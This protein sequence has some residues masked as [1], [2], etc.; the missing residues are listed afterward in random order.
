MG[1][2]ERGGE[3]CVGVGGG[4]GGGRGWCPPIQV[5]VFHEKDQLDGN[6]LTLFIWRALKD[7]SFDI[8]PFYENS[9]FMEMKIDSHYWLYCTMNIWQHR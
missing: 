4:G 8:L 7:K 1:G 9:G 3:G 2:G 5:S 6:I